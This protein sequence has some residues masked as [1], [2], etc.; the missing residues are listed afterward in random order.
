[1]NTN[2]S[3]P[4]RN[5]WLALGVQ[6]LLL[7]SVPA[8]A[9]YTLNTG[10][11]VFLKTA[12][13]DPV[14]LL[15]GYY[16]TLKYEISSTNNLIN[17]PGGD[18]NYYSKELTNE[19]SVTKWRSGQELFV[20]LELPKGRSAAKPIAV[21]LQRPTTIPP[22]AVILRGVLDGSQ[23]KY[24]LERFYMPEQQQATVNKDLNQAQARSSQNLLMEVKIGRDGHAVPVAIW[25]G[26]RSYRF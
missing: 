20:T 9:L 12:P 13:I 4:A 16:Q 6:L 1:M 23:V 5:F 15:R 17:L 10:T 14:D 22:N 8:P 25:V 26:D 19:Q 7:V 18:P 11:Q 24:D 3:I 21:S 2:S